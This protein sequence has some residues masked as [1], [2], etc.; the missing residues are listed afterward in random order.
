METKTLRVLQVVDSLGAGGIQ[1]FILNINRNINLD[2]IKFDYLV[3][4]NK[5]EREFYDESVEKMGG[6]IICLQQN[7]GIKRIKSFIDLYKL[8]KEKKYKVV[9]IH[10]DRAKSFFEAVVFKLCKTPKIIMHSHN[11]RMSKDKKLYYLH[12]G[13]QNI[14]K[15]LWKYTVNYEFACSTNAAEWMFADSDINASKAQVINNGIDE[16][17]F[18]F[19]EEIRQKYRKKLNIQEKFVIAHV[20]RF[21]YQKNH[22][23]LIDIFNS[24]IK[25]Y[26][27]S[28][29]LLVGE[30]EL[31]EEITEK[32]KNL[33]L[34]DKVIFYGLSNE[35]HNIL[36]AADIFVFPSHFEGLPVVGIE[37]Q[38]SGLMTI[39]SDTIS[40]EVKITDYW[41]S[42]PLSKSCEEWAE[43]ILK[44]KDGYIR[45][46]TSKE[47]ID[48]GFSARQISKKLEDLYINK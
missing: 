31:K 42:V 46:D 5:N 4:R 36:Q 22:N 6:N 47:I 15:H 45:K 24:V 30:G 35:I 2:K 12:L 44:Y 14:I 21:S 41:A 27:D 10:G 26:S 17:K 40:D 16:Q 38:A 11:D 9:H 3:Y 39:A 28:V 43:I 18:I 32:V 13:M 29:L 33:K 37:V 34:Q 8:Q 7:K 19:N 1:A 20:G 48:S 23:F 25:R